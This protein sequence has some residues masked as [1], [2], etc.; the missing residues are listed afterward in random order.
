[1]VLHVKI[2]DTRL[3]CVCY[4][5]IIDES[6]SLIEERETKAIQS[7]PENFKLYR[8]SKY[9]SRIVLQY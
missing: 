8:R 6:D 2:R 7:R 5:H 1:M 9:G 3:C 4:L